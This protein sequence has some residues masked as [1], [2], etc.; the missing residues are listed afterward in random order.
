MRRKIIDFIQGHERLRFVLRCIKRFGDDEFVYDVNHMYE[1]LMTIKTIQNGERQKGKVLYKITVGG[2]VGLFAAF[3]YILLQMYFADSLG[4]YPIVVL[5]ENFPYYDSEGV[6]GTKNPWEYYFNQYMG[7]TERDLCEGYRVVKNQMPLLSDSLREIDTINSYRVSNEFIEELAVTA[8][9]Y[10]SLRS[11]V[12]MEIEKSIADLLGEKKTLGV[13]IRMGDM[14]A[15]YDGHPIVPSLDIYIERINKAM[16]NEQFERIFLATDDKRALD[17]MIKVYGEKLV[18]YEAVTRVEGM[19]LPI[20]LDRKDSGY[21]CGLEVLRDMYTLVACHGLVAG[22]SQVST[23]SR[24][25]K[26]S[27]MEKYQYLDIID[28]G[29]NKNDLVANEENAKMIV[30]DELQK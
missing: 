27:L 21:V 25:I 9:K 24:I 19:Y 15:N 13:Q 26:E 14:M 29:L 18:Y 4:L 5:E 10:V 11:E 20:D 3:R 28:C 30:Q 17:V 1:D 8:R 16:E 6:R 23:T 7:L 22:M 12:K 2:R